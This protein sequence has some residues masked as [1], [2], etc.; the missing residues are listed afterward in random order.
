MLDDAEKLSKLKVE[1][2]PVDLTIKAP[3][4][5]KKGAAEIQLL[6]AKKRM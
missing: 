5:S 1:K 4:T 6:E 2:R 3:I